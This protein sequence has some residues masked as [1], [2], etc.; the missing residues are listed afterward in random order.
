MTVARVGTYI[1][2][3]VSGEM[4]VS[5]VQSNTFLGVSAFC[6]PYPG[7]LG[8]R[9]V[10][11]ST[12]TFPFSNLILLYLNISFFQPHTAVPEH[13][14]LPLLPLLLLDGARIALSGIFSEFSSFHGRYSK[15]T[16]CGHGASW[17]DQGKK[18]G[19]MFLLSLTR[20]PSTVSCRGLVCL[21]S[22]EK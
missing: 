16:S 13:L 9:C 15:R 8:Y 3:R 7:G 17:R 21:F 6:L 2:F 22:G 4:W 19:E 10:Q 12:S 14:I 11:P 5:K 20:Q 1:Q 18:A